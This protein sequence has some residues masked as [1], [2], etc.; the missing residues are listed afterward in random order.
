MRRQAIAEVA[1]R[2]GVSPNAVNRFSRTLGYGGYRDFSLALELG[3]VLGAATA[4]PGSPAAQRAVIRLVAFGQQTALGFGT[5]RGSSGSAGE[6]DE[7]P[8]WP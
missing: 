5:G 7:W 8:R 3:R 4:V 2:A 1:A 6:E